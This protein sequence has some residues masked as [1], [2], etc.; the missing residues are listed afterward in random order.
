MHMLVGVGM[1]SHLLMRVRARGDSGIRNRRLPASRPRASFV[2]DGV[3]S[4]RVRV[5]ARERRP[6]TRAAAY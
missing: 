4:R 6:R 3:G 2:F 1:P 5:R